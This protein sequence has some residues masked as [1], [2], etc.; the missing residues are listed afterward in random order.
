MESSKEWLNK[1]SDGVL[2]QLKTQNGTI[3]SSPKKNT[4]NLNEYFIQKVG[5]IP[6]N[7][8]EKPTENQ[9]ED[10]VDTNNCSFSLKEVDQNIVFKTAAKMKNS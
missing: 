1:K 2:R 5:S 6:E 10:E 9:D 3:S 8:P 4:N 7:L